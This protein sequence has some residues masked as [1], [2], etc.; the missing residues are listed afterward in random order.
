MFLMM[1][2]PNTDSV[3]YLHVVTAASGRTEDQQVLVQ[4]NAAKLIAKVLQG[5]YVL[6][7]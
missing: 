2:A 5:T 3:S 7:E 1:I 6:I 4:G